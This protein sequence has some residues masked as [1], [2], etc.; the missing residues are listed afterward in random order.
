MRR[1]ASAILLLF[2]LFAVLGQSCA[3]VLGGRSNTLVF[4]SEDAVSAK[5]Y[6][7]GGYIGDAPGKIKLE[8]KKIQH[9][10]MLEIQPE[11]KPSTNY[12]ILRKQSILY[13]LL[14]TFSGGVWLGIDVAT[15]NIYRPS[16]RI[17]DYTNV[18]SSK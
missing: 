6:L 17:F 4:K 10:S 7:D 3:T 18:P 2:I 16:P 5:V 1:N 13:T 11:G 9:G 8:K 12:L 15:G 14:D